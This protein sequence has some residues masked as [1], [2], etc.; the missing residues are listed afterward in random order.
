MVEP[1]LV[2]LSTLHGPMD[3]ERIISIVQSKRPYPLL[4]LSRPLLGRQQ[5]PLS[6]GKP[7]EAKRAAMVGL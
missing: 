7:T 2:H 6:G 1:V 5:Y 4:A 3:I